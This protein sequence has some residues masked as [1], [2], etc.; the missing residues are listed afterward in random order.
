VARGEWLATMN[1]TE[2]QAGSDLGLVRTRAE[3]Q[4][5]RQACRA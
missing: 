3:P 1:L 4:A 2:P 5:R